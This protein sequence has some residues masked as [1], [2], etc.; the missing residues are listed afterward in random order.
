MEEKHGDKVASSF[1]FHYFIST[2]CGISAVSITIGEHHHC[3]ATT[4]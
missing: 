1:S 2:Y 4:P 3:E